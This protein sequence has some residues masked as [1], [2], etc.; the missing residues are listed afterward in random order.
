[1]R[2]ANRGTHIPNRYPCAARSADRESLCAGRGAVAA[3][4]R[5]LCIR[6]AHCVALPGVR[7]RDGVPA[8]LQPATSAAATP[9]AAAH[10]QREPICVVRSAARYPVCS[11]MVV[12]ACAYL[13]ACAVDMPE[14]R[15]SLTRMRLRSHLPRSEPQCGAGRTTYRTGRLTLWTETLCSVARARHSHSV[16]CAAAHATAP[17]QKSA[18]VRPARCPQRA[19]IKPLQAAI[20]LLRIMAQ[21]NPARLRVAHPQAPPKVTPQ[22]T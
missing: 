9:F 19:S 11:S 10:D 6:G 12:Q 21:R 14:T 8:R 20:C 15:M 1:M 5:A 4:G 3:C 13:H 2:L 7:V 16:E 17:T 22:P 18:T